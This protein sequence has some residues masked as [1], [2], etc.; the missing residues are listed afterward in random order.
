MNTVIQ[1][2]F[3]RKSVRVFLDKPVS[4][5][6]I[7]TIIDAGIQA[8]S[9]GNQQFY[10][11]LDVRDQ[12][13]KDRLAVLCDHQP[14]IAAAQLVLVFL[15]DTRRWLDC[16]RYAGAEARKPGSGDLLIACEDAVIAAQNMVS[17]A[18]SLGIGSC[19]IGDILENK[20]QVADLL[21]LDPLV[22]PIT[23]LVFG[24]PA[25][26]QV[27]R[28]KPPRPDRK[29]LVQRDFYRPLTETELRQMHAEIHAA[30]SGR[31]DF[32]F[33][34]FM[35]A[36]CKRKYMSDFAVEMNRSVEEYLKNFNG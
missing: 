15:A 13:V 5:E 17:A 20:E 33:N 36:F 26:F 11:I 28:P 3:D 2:L 7:N 31:S 9:A 35:S 22:L 10:T 19:Y 29:Y 32:D 12:S 34:A 30:D 18:E 1:S 4:E 16:Y 25:E 14:F 23:M 21:H 8:P 24:Y 6:H 27:K